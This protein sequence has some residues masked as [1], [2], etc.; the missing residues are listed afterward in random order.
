MCSVPI[1]QGSRH[2]VILMKKK[3]R[4]CIATIQSILPVFLNHEW[5]SQ[6]LIY[7][8]IVTAEII[9]FCTVIKVIY[10]INSNS[11]IRMN[12]IILRISDLN[13]H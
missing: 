11:M 7:T 10:D 6:F 1:Q 12:F 4:P 9:P 2:I 8:A 13:S 5:S 3:R